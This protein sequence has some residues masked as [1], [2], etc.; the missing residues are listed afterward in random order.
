MMVKAK[1]YL[2]DNASTPCGHNR[3]DRQDNGDPN[4][5]IS[6]F[7]QDSR[8]D[9]SYT[10]DSCYDI[11]DETMDDE[12]SENGVNDKNQSYCKM[13]SISRSDEYSQED[14][15]NEY[16]HEDDPCD[17]LSRIEVDVKN[18]KE[19]VKVFCE[20]QGVETIHRN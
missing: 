1:D 16:S 6:R 15:A 17:D 4:A 8:Q 19:I 9:K 11:K 13:T 7:N 2:P 12:S 10:Y 14:S 18:K 20:P 5:N 3:S